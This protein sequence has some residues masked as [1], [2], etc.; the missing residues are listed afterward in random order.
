MYVYFVV[1]THTRISILLLNTEAILWFLQ[2]V[3]QMGGIIEPC[4]ILNYITIISFFFQY[5]TKMISTIL[6]IRLWKHEDYNS[7]WLKILASTYMLVFYALLRKN[8]S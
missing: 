8:T 7:F 4:Q 5:I 2:T 1:I 3:R 6:V